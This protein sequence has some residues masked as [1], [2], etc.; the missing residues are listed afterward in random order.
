MSGKFYK[1]LMRVIC[2]SFFLCMMSL[3]SYSQNERFKSLYIYN[4]AKNIEWP[5]HGKGDFII[6]VLGYSPMFYELQ[7]NVKG[8]I[9]DRQT[10]QIKQASNISGIE[11]CNI[12]YIPAQQSNLLGAAQKHLAG[13]PTLIVTE[14]N[15]MMRQGSDINILQSGGKLQFEINSEQ[16]SNKDIVAS[17]TLL[18]LGIIYAPDAAKKKIEL[19]SV[20]DASRPR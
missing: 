7:Q 4:F 8:K 16:L 19:E 3:V 2:M 17:K 9:I 13:E 12:L 14:K 20:D 1:K 6:T 10:I 15:G 5:D 11:K 18:R